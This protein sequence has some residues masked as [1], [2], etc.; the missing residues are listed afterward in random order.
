MSTIHRVCYAQFSEQRVIGLVPDID[1]AW[2]VRTSLNVRTLEYSKSRY[3]PAVMPC[4]FLAPTFFPK[5]SCLVSEI[6]SAFRLD[7]DGRLTLG[8][9][10]FQQSFERLQLF[11]DDSQ[12]SSYHFPDTGASCPSRHA[13]FLDFIFF[14]KLL[15]S[16]DIRCL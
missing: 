13:C 16:T 7:N 14:Q 1:A 3:W 10:E 9:C 15:W 2:F 4:V 11:L 12:Q 5:M 6:D 8:V